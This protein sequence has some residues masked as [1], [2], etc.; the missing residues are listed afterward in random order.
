MTTADTIPIDELSNSDER[1]T[2]DRS[3]SVIPDSETSAGEEV[4]EVSELNVPVARVNEDGDS[5][6]DSAPPSSSGSSFKFYS[7]RFFK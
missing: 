2:S 1:S 7:Y 3:V 5:I 6:R 4:P